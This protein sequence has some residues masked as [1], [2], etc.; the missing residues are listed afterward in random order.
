MVEISP[1]I[2]THP[3]AVAL[4]SLGQ[5][6]TPDPDVQTLEPIYLR[7]AFITEAKRPWTRV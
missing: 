5:K 2:L 6:V 4:A 1:A 3:S 7:D